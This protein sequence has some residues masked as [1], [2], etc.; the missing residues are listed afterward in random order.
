MLAVNV[1]QIL[2]GYD[3]RKDEDK[4]ILALSRRWTNVVTVYSIGFLNYEKVIKFSRLSDTE[5]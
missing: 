2:P 4:S 3:H 1:L 5:K